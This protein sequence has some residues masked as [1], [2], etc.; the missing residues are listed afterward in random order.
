MN[1][2]AS[3]RKGAGGELEIV[4]MFRAAGFLQ[5]ARALSGAAED[6]GDVA[7]VPDLTVEV[8]CWDNFQESVNVALNELAVEQQNNHTRWGVGFVKRRRKGW[9][10]VM[11][12]EQWVALYAALHGLGQLRI[13]EGQ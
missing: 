13:E 6:R 4:Q 5:A 8:K 2:K 10:A 12:A 3:R 9:V 7:G 11:P 1:G